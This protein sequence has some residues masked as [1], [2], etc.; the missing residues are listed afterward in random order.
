MASF[1]FLSA[2][3]LRHAIATPWL[4]G[5]HEKRALSF[6]DQSLLLSTLSMLKRLNGPESDDLPF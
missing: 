5:K 1:S 3:G 6:R 4:E 2:I